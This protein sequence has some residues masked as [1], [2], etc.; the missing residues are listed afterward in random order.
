MRAVLSGWFLLFSG[1]LLAGVQPESQEP[2]P[3]PEEVH[4]TVDVELVSV[5]LTA[6][7][8]SGKFITNLKPEELILKED[9]VPQEIAY[10]DLSSESEEEPL[11]VAILIDTSVSMNER[12]KEIPKIQMAK[13]GATLLLSQLIPQDRM[14]LMRFNDR[15]SEATPLTSDRPLIQE[16][17]ELLKT[18]Y[19]RTALLDAIQYVNSRLK[20]EFG[21]KLLFICSDGQ[22]NA[23]EISLAKMLEALKNSSDTMILALGVTA[24]ESKTKWFG[25]EEEIKAGEAALRSLAEATGGY[26]FFP[27]N[28]KDL[29]DVK[30]TL[31]QVVPSQYT[32]TYRPKRGPDGAWRTIEIECKRKGVKLKHR[33]GYLAK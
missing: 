17:L 27:K 24:F 10:L 7:D 14:L 21:R 23:S 6:I 19:G 11:T 20:E 1:I 15:P 13:E 26:A 22:D 30:I 28:L 4:E 8:S 33:T 31:R 9:G 32:I 12:Y 29:E 16:S 2:E 25:M 5:Y 3:Q 18:D